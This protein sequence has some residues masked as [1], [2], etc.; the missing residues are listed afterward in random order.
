MG[1]Q[2][3]IDAGLEAGAVSALKWTVGVGAVVATG[4]TLSPAFA[5]FS[6]SVKTAMVLMLVRTRPLRCIDAIVACWGAGRSRIG[7]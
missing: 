7:C 6:P 2:E 3:A 1:R 5:K 4:H